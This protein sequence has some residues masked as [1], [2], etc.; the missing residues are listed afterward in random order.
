VTKDLPTPVYAGGIYLVKDD[1]L[2]LIPSE[3]RQV[4]I[5]RRP[6]VVVSGPETNSDLSWPFVLACPLSTST[7]RRTRFDVELAAGQGNLTKKTWVRIPAVQPFMKRD[8]QD[9]S[10]ILEARLIEQ[11]HTRLVQYMGLI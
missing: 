1:L 7:T 11:I 2:R 6:L 3:E 5:T 9:H 8:L 4:H 10:G